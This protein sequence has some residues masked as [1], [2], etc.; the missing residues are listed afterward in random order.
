MLEPD[1]GGRAGE[2]GDAGLRGAERV[3]EAREAGGERGRVPAAGGFESQS[4]QT[5]G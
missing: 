1:V 4:L 2:E 3:E 5:G